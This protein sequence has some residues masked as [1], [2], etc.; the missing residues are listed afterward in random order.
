MAAERDGD[1]KRDEGPDDEDEG[2]EVEVM[3]LVVIDE[4]PI[5]AG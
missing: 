4:V 3:A 5:E 1:L 2:Y